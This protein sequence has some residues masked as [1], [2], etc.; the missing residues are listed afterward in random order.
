MQNP[1]SKVD[2]TGS[3]AVPGAAVE[4]PVEAPGAPG[5]PSEVP[6]ESDVSD[7]QTESDSYRQHRCSTLH[8]ICLLGDFRGQFQ[9]HGVSGIFGSKWRLFGST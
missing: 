1:K 4:A 5:A 6:T 9:S 3:A 7:V 8:G 2:L